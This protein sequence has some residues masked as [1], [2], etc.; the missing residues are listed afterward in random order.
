MLLLATH[1]VKLDAATIQGQ[2][3]FDGCIYYTQAS[4]MQLLFNNYNSVEL[5]T[6][7]FNYVGVLE[8]HAELHA[9]VVHMLVICDSCTCCLFTH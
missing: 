5:R 1:V 9:L 6:S 8:H 7:E 3:L 4:S 2:L